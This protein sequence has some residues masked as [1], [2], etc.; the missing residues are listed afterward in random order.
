MTPGVANVLPD[1]EATTQVR[2]ILAGTMQV[3]SSKRVVAY[4]EADPELFRKLEEMAAL[5]PSPS[6]R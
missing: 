1:R 3:H 4:T 2:G 5:A 6:S